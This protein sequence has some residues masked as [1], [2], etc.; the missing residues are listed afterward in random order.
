MEGE[1]KGL[2]EAVSIAPVK[3]NFS[4]KEATDFGLGTTQ[5]GSESG[6]G[7]ALSGKAEKALLELG[8]FHSNSVCQS[9]IEG[10]Q[11]LARKE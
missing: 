11:F 8:Q 6:L 5:P 2:D 1:A 9:G 7:H 4:G 3:T 10:K